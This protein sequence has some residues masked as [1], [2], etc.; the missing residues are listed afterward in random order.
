LIISTGIVALFK[1]T[2]M[3]F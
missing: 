3:M 2:G 1:F